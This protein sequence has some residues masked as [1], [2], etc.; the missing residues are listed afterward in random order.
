MPAPPFCGTAGPYY[1]LDTQSLE[2]FSDHTVYL[3]LYEGF[4]APSYERF[5]LA[6]DGTVDLRDNVTGCMFTLPLDTHTADPDAARAFVE[7][8]GIPWEPMTDA[9]L[10]VQEA[11]EDLEVEKS[12][13]GVGNQTFLIQEAN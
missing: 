13:D 6:E 7:S 4:A 10:A 3:A 11:H 5:S 12:A 1:V 8:T 2:I 9:Q